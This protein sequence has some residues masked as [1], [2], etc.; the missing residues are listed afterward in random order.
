LKAKEM[1]NVNR[2]L[3]LPICITFSLTGC[4]TVGNVAQSV[5]DSAR[6]GSKGVET[7]KTKV[8]ST[9]VQSTPAQVQSAATSA[10][11]CE[12]NFVSTGSFF[13]GRQLRTNAPLPGVS[14]D[15]AYKKVFAEMAK[16]GWQIISS[17]KDVR[18][19]SASEGVPGSK[20]TLPFNVVVGEEKGAATDISFTISMPGGVMAS[21]DGVKAMFCDFTKSL[22]G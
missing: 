11:A 4:E 9:A 3:L 2:C 20:K 18:M 8:P 1:M 22:G 16:R 7:E 5:A 17:D 6:G 12:R 19:I 10:P 13:S 15:T 14:P 21:E